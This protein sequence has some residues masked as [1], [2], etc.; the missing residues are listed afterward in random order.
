MYLKNQIIF[1]FFH[2]S[3]FRFVFVD[4]VLLSLVSFYFVFISLISFRFV[5][6]LLISFRFIS[7]S[8]ISFRFVSFLFRFA[9]YR[10]P[11]MNT[12][13]YT[14]SHET[15]TVWSGFTVIKCFSKI[16]A[17]A[18]G[19][20]PIKMLYPINTMFW[21]VDFGIRV[22]STYLRDI[23]LQ[24]RIIGGISDVFIHDS[25]SVMRLSKWVSERLFSNFNWTWF[26][27]NNVHLALRLTHSLTHAHTHARTHAR[28]SKYVHNN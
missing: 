14:N 18:L 25:W 22:Q 23:W 20:W 8:L 3:L 10:Y 6:F 1:F 13:V 4:F 7:F 2:I 16:F 9:L 28:K 26:C 5:S 21:F 15:T 24:R 17:L 19:K 12:M 11:V 27:W